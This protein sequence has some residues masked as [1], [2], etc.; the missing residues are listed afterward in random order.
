MIIS[1]ATSVC[2]AMRSSGRQRNG[3]CSIGDAFLMGTIK[4][5]SR[6]EYSTRMHTQVE[7][8]SAGDSQPMWP[9]PIAGDRVSLLDPPKLILHYGSLYGKF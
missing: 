2:D 1:S 5:P 9:W 8:V 4:M 7:R 6:S 3:P